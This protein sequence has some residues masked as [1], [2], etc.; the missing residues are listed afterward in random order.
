M[1]VTRYTSLAS[2]QAFLQT[3][4]PSAVCIA[5]D[6]I[7]AALYIAQNPPDG[8]VLV[9]GRAGGN[10]ILLVFSTTGTIAGLRDVDVKGGHFLAFTGAALPSP[11]LG[12]PVQVL[13]FASAKAL[14]NYLK[15]IDA[16]AIV[17]VYPDEGSV[18]DAAPNIFTFVVSFGRITMI[19][20][21]A[22]GVVL[23]IVDKGG[24]YTIVRK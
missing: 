22:L 10:N 5:P 6:D 11:V 13:T 7:A 20:G 8:K 23:F 14:E 18:N 12:K 3:L 16:G 9:M 4:D 24:E 19:Q 15:T 17:T 21:T 2:L 1:A